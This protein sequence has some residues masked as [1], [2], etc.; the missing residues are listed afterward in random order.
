MWRKLIFFVI[1]IS[2]VQGSCIASYTM[3][4]IIIPLQDVESCIAI[5]NLEHQN[6]VIVLSL[7]PGLGYGRKVS[8]SFLHEF[9]SPMSST[10]SN[11]T[12]GCCVEIN[13]DNEPTEKVLLELDQSVPSPDNS[14]IIYRCKVS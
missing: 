3:Y 13:R 14:C 4:K 7:F 2:A 6:I 5:L 8:L 12:H 9:A 1:L 11:C 10:V